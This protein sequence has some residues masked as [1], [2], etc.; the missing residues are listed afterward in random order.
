[1]WQIT[2]ETSWLHCD[3]KDLWIEPVRLGMLSVTQFSIRTT[4][5]AQLDFQP[6]TPSHTTREPIHGEF[7]A[8]DAISDPGM[9][10]VRE[11]IQ[12]SLD[13]RRDGETVLVRILFSDKGNSTVS[14]VVAPYFNGA[15][16]HLRAAGNGIHPDDL[17]VMPYCE[18]CVPDDRLRQ[19]DPDQNV[20][21]IPV[22]VLRCQRAIPGASNPDSSYEDKEKS[23]HETLHQK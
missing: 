13:A 20:T 23:R 12:N 2:D 8:A 21:E 5:M 22:S 15:W 6:L 16:D 11:G 1:M 4:A 18:I 3:S 14:E 9:A 10:L 19:L 17:F 7:F